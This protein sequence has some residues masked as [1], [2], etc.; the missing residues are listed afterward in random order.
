MA[1]MPKRVK[2]RKTQRGRIRGNATR[3]NYVAFGDYGLMALERG[4]VTARQIEAIR[5][6]SSRNI[7]DGKYWIRIFPHKP[8]TSTAAETRMGKGKGE[9]DFW[10]AVVKPGHILFEVAGVTEDMARHIFRLQSA[11]L[12]VRVK[13]V[14]RRAH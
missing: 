4:W 5:V 13:M 12:P 10:C 11:K 2:Y 3:G 1:M 8:V 6:V 7:G 14:N 9:V